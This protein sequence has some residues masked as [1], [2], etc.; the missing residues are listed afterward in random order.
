MSVY[1]CR[2]ASDGVPGVAERRAEQRPGLEVLGHRRGGE[3]G[4]ARGKAASGG[5]RERLEAEVDVD[6][7]LVLL[8]E[9]Q[10]GLVAVGGRKTTLAGLPSTLG[11]GLQAHLQVLGVVAAPVEAFGAAEPFVLAAAPEPALVRA[12]LEHGDLV[13][14]GV[15]Q[16]PF[17]GVEAV[18]RLFE[19]L[20]GLVDGSA[21]WSAWR[22]RD[23]IES[24]LTSK[25]V[26]AMVVSQ[27]SRPASFM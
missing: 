27:T 10:P 13:G 7:P 3:L 1:F 19:D 18:V 5:V 23:A 4:V 12:Q 11:H 8:V 16:Q 26:W 14:L 25:R 21:Y 20:D 9:L 6:L 17:V 15:G 24:P 2:S 22:M